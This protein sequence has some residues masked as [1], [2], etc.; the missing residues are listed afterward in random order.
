MISVRI[1]T[2]MLGTNTAIGVEE[3]INASGVGMIVAE[4]VG[5][6]ETT[7]VVGVMVVVIGGVDISPEVPVGDVVGVEGVTGDV[8]GTG[9]GVV[10]VVV[11]VV[12]I[13]VVVIVV[14]G[15]I[16]VD[17]VVGEIDVGGATVAVVVIIVVGVTVIEVVVVVVGI[18][19][20]GVDGGMVVVGTV[21]ECVVEDMM[22]V[23]VEGEGAGEGAEEGTEGVETE[24]SGEDEVGDAMD[25][26]EAEDIA[27][28][29]SFEGA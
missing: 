25:G 12:G 24:G 21:V 3:L 23:E 19:V 4:L 29:I 1:M 9:T 13:T 18:V 26:D 16:V 10:V 28:K 6:V 22:V 8:D 11:A 20:D 27:C 5:K 15:I 7:G 2:K 17:D 14:V